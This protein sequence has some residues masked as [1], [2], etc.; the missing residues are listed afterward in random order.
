MTK[1]VDVP[2]TDLSGNPLA[3]PGGKQPFV[4]DVLTAALVNATE[5]NPTAADKYA[6]YKL[7]RK[8]DKGGDV[9]LSPEDL[10]LIKLVVGQVYGPLV[11]GQVFEWSDA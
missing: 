2:L 9:E 7:A 6:R 11:V 1:N 5:G 4:K 10:V 8:L 3:E